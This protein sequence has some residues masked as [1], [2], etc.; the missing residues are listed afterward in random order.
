MYRDE[1]D[2]ER[3]FSTPEY[4]FK[5]GELI[6]RNGAVVK[7]TWGRYHTVEPAYDRGIERRLKEHFDRYQTIRAASLQISRDEMAAFGHGA[8]VRTHP[9]RRGTP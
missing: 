5:D 4:V 2:R 7:V 8:E 3:M 9:C 6:V 1:P